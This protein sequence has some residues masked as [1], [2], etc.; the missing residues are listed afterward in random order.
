MASFN[1]N[2]M[3]KVLWPLLIVFVLLNFSDVLTTLAAAASLNGFVEFNPL[4]ARLLKLGF[5]GFM[6]AYLSKFVIIVPLF[7]MVGVHRS[8]PKVDFQVRLLKFTALV[9]LAALDIGFGAIVIG[10]NLPL[11]IRYM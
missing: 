5:S 1:L 6:L 3:Q 7:Y 9:V 2:L 11:L 4:G 10:N 8:D